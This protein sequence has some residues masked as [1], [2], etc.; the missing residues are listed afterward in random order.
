MQCTCGPHPRI[1]LTTAYY[2]SN[3]HCNSNGNNSNGKEDGNATTHESK[4]AVD[5]VNDLLLSAC[6]REIRNACRSHGCFHVTIHLGKEEEE[7][8]NNDSHFPL[9]QCLS[10]SRGE[11]ESDI[12]SLFAPKFLTDAI[13]KIPKIILEEDSHHQHRCSSD[14]SN[15][16]AICN[17]GQYEVPFPSLKTRSSSNP[18]SETTKNNTTF[19]KMATFRGRIA[20]SG[21]EEQSNPEPKLSWEFQ[22]C[23]NGNSNVSNGAN[24]DN[25][26]PTAAMEEA[27]NETKSDDENNGNAAELHNNDSSWS[28]LPKYTDALHSV[29]STIIGLLDIP[30]Q[31]VL[32]E[33]QCQCQCCC[34]NDEHD[35]ETENKANDCQRRC[36]IDLL[37][38]FRYDAL[39]FPS[40]S[41]DIAITM[42]SSSHSDWGSLTIVWQDDKGGL[43]TYCHA[44]DRWS[45]VVAASDACTTTS[46]S[47]CNNGSECIKKNNDEVC[48]LFVHVGDFLSLATLGGE[49]GSVPSWPSPRHRV[50]CPIRS[51][52]SGSVS[53]ESSNGSSDKGDAKDCRR[54]LVYF[55]YPPPGISLD[56]A[57]RFVAPLASTPSSAKTS[58]SSNDTNSY[59]DTYSLLHNQTHQ[60]SDN[61]NN[62]INNN[63][64]DGEVQNEQE[65][66]SNTAW[67]TYQ[68]IKGT[69]F[70]KVIFDKWNQVQ[71]KLS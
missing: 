70:E 32:Q 35:D 44:C 24:N 3:R 34:S 39:S 13:Q 21:D 41:T 23:A 18:S 28:L 50:L 37:R 66:R 40:S 30:P 71:R 26:V 2:Q 60:P 65:S 38:V 59:F 8:E 7:G 12:E 16:D 5:D 46:D 6:R 56:D 62:A 63:I 48:R 58:P 27:A 67:Q 69:S 4:N 64:G 33:G 14:G 19:T 20:E 54:S 36:N 61:S 11:I 10:K 51:Q 52:N 57:Q 49:D 47:T 9:L 43:Q 68:Q 42:G 1:D 22:R 29:A 53:S 25:N 45:D 31:L 55:A 17:G 15:W